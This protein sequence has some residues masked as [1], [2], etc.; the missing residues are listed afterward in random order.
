[1]AAGKSDRCIVPSKPGTCRQPPQSRLVLA[2][3]DADRKLV[4]KILSDLASQSDRSSLVD[5]RCTAQDTYCRSQFVLGRLLHADQQPTA[6]PVAARP[7]LDQIVDLLPT[8]QIEIP[9]AKSGPAERD[10]TNPLIVHRPKWA[11]SSSTARQP[12][13]DHHPLQDQRLAGT[14]NQTSRLPPPPR[15][16][17][18]RLWHN[19]RWPA[20]RTGR[21]ERSLPAAVS[22]SYSR[23][24]TPA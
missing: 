11:A 19:L 3:R 16:R 12:P 8:A 9:D 2:G 20:K 24:L 14:G 23:M 21:V 7:L 15:L 10:R 5:V 18:N 13:G 6:V 1:M 4:A 17:M 22:R